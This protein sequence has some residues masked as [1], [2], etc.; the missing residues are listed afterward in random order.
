[1]TEETFD[2]RARIIRAATRLLA[3][4]DREAV[5]TRAVDAAA[6]V[7]APTIYR[8]FG[9]MQGLLDAVAGEALTDYGRQKRVAERSD[10][11]VQDML[12]G[13]DH[14]VAFGLANLVAYLLMFS[15]SSKLSDSPAR[16][17]G[18]AILR[19]LVGPAAQAGRLAVAVPHAASIMSSA[20]RG[21][22]LS[23]IAAAPGECDARCPRLR[24][25]R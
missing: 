24:V 23:L 1:M 3:S 16:R 21:V 2:V 9:D 6:G 12:R 17:E 8:Q 18:E 11:P 19:D 22:V 4:G 20:C 15:D 7:Q 14:H 25:K 13:W 10:D 5:P